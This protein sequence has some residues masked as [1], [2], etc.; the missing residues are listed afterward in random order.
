MGR[1]ESHQTEQESNG[2]FLRSLLSLVAWATL[3][4]CSLFLTTV[5]AIGLGVIL[6]HF[7][8]TELTRLKIYVAY[9]AVSS[10]FAL[11]VA[12]RWFR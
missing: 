9:Y 10:P 6:S 4:A 1:T 11:L 2:F 5:G 12:F 7:G 8:V 3:T